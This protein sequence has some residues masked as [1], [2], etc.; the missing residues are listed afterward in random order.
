MEQNA[1]MDS[2]E[3]PKGCEAVG[4]IKE[5]GQPG[6]AKWIVLIFFANCGQSKLKLPLRN[7]R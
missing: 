6:P 1:A 5:S 4:D 2:P 7:E 3:P